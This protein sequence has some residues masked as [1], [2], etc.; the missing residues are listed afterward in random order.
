MGSEVYMTISF[1]SIS[2]A[3]ADEILAAAMDAYGQ[4]S[5]MSVSY[6]DPIV[7]YQGEAE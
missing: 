6:S 2:A 5:G 3:K 7:D 4:L 1:N